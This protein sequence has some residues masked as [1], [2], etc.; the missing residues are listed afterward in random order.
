MNEE[1]LYALVDFFAAMSQEP[2]LSVPLRNRCADLEA[3]FNSVWMRE[4]CK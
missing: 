3:R 2:T 4:V 1:D